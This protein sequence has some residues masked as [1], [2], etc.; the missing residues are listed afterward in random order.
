MYDNVPGE[1][2]SSTEIMT[3]KLKKGTP[4]IFLVPDRDEIRRERAFHHRSSRLGA[5]QDPVM[6]GRDR[7][8]IRSQILSP[9]ASTV[10]PTPVFPDYQNPA[11]QS[12]VCLKMLS[13]FRITG[14]CDKISNSS[15]RVPKAEKH[16]KVF[17]HPSAT[18]LDL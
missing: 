11:G 17:P 7:R 10:H 15:V 2:P 6:I 9:A 12:P 5:Q 4:A 18:E 3:G 16:T 14:F 1:S 8:Q 13:C